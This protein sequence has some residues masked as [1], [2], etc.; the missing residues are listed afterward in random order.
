MLRTHT[1]GELTAKDEGKDVTVCGWVHRRRDHGGLIF[2]DLRDR[3]GLT[4]LTI[5]P[6]KNKRAWK[7]A[8]AVRSEYVLIARGTVVKRPA[9]MVNKKL[10]TGAIEI[11]VSDVTILNAAKTPPFEIALKVGEDAVTQARNL[12]EE[13]RMKYRYLDLRREMIREKIEMRSRAI[14]FIREFMWKEGFQEIETPILTKS[15]PEGA[16]DFLVPSRLHPG[17]FYAL[18]QSPQQYKQLLMVAGFDKYFQIAPC[19]RDEDPRIDRSPDQFYQLDIEQSFAEQ[20]DVLDLV[21]RL[22]TS[23]VEKLT[24]KRILKKPWPRLTYDEAMEKYG[25]DKPD[26]RFGLEIQHV[27]DLVKDCHFQVFSDAVARGGVVKAI[28]AKGAA[29]FS[30][31]QIDEL[32]EFVK[33]SG[34]KGLA[35]LVVEKGGVKSPIAKF[36]GD[37]LTKLLLKSV[38]AKAGDIVFF[39][40]GDKRVVRDSLGALRNELGRRLGLKDPNLCAFAFVVDFPLF[41]EDKHDGHYAPMHHMFTR[42]KEEDVPLLETN[43]HMVKSYQ[44]DMV[45]NGVEV[46]GGS[47]RIYDRT[48]QEK[49]FELIGFTDEQR[50]YFH[51]MLEAFEYGAPPHGGIAPGV[52]RFLMVLMNEDN[53]RE[54]MPFPK[55]GDVRELMMDSPST[56]DEQQLKDVHICV[57]P[58]SK[59]TS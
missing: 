17:Q 5:N 56:V 29:V 37:E 19:F 13:V 54:V 33:K 58:V 30:R 41:E 26:L 12:N 36:L 23:L 7:T 3:Y 16:R 1:C 59:S 21:E 22:F 39:G 2:I 47:I 32:T 8:D 9:T 50:S 45:L 4:Q 25:V 15:T 55:T 38:G 49:I 10:K 14:R 40:A 57:S 52:D 46:G 43:P 53:I 11:E 24:T 27:S 31:A 42:P 35:Y 44:H 6:I 20:N 48:T 18:P 28:C 34:A 51:H